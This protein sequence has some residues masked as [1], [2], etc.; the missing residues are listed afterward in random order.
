MCLFA[1]E[2]CLSAGRPPPSPARPPSP[3][4][5]P[6]TPRTRSIS[7]RVPF[8]RLCNLLPNVFIRF[9]SFANRI[10]CLPYLISRSHSFC[11]LPRGGAKK[12][13][14]PGDDDFIRG[15]GFLS[16][17]F[18]VF[19]IPFLHFSCYFRSLYISK[20]TKNIAS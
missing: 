11:V 5:Q 10:S 20:S 18:T 14:Q 12:S 8:P 1:F 3:L 15:W 17:P 13:R 9:S 2:P 19:T 16:F 6:V 7:S 4:P